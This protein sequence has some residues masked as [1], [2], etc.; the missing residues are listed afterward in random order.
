MDKYYQ[1]ILDSI[2]E[3]IDFNFITVKN[4]S[5]RSLFLDN[6]SNMS[7]LFT[8]ENGEGYTFEPSSGVVQRHRKQ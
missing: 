3:S 2:P 1:Q 6:Q 8:I 5:V 7:I 4:E